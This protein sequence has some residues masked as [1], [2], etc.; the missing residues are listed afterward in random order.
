MHRPLPTVTKSRLP[1]I[2]GS[3]FVVIVAI[4]AGHFWTTR[5]ATRWQRLRARR[6]A[7]KKKTESA[8]VMRSSSCAAIEHFRK[9]TE[10]QGKR[11]RAPPRGSSL[12]TPYADGSLADWEGHIVCLLRGIPIVRIRHFTF[13]STSRLRAP[14]AAYFDFGLPSLNQIEDEHSGL[15]LEFDLHTDCTFQSSL[16]LMTAP[17]WYLV[18]CEVIDLQ[19]DTEIT[20]TSS[21]GTLSRSAFE[22]YE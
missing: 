17:P 9:G 2:I 19:T 15:H 14:M 18:Y 20:C 7:R 12:G 1:P 3:S 8:S 11:C 21:R 22:V 10:R 13:A 5:F 6:G 16:A 4:S